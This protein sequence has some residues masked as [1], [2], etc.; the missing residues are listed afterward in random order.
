MFLFPLSPVISIRFSPPLIL[1]RVTSIL[2]N[3]LVTYA[4]YAASEFLQTD[5]PALRSTRFTILYVTVHE[6]ILL[7]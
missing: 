1:E 3:N 2:R 4:A 6:K 5:N 7:F